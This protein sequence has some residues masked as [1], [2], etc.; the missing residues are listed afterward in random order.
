MIHVLIH[1]SN[2]LQ[3]EATVQREPTNAKA[4]FDLGVKQQENERESQALLALRRAVELDPVHLPSWLALATSST[5]EGLRQ[6]TIDAAREWV[7]RN[8]R[9]SNTVAVH[10]GPGETFDSLIAC[11]I[12]MARHA[13]EEVDA[14]VQIALAVLLNANEDYHKAY[15]CFQTALAAR[16]DDWVLYN[17]VGATL[18]NSGAADQAISY[19]Y[20]AL[21]LNP[22]YIRARFNL[23]I[24]CISLG[25]YEE[26]AH[27]ILDALMLQDSDSVHGQD[28][29]GVTTTSLWDSLRTTC[30]H[31]KRID[32]ASLCDS[33]NLDSMRTALAGR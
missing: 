11:L 4:W 2:V 24:S 10:G 14:D 6:D 7:V 33:R 32:L 29:R 22:G 5:N 17:R 28:S 23:G 18:A 20:R 27:H 21:E 12:S 8:E 31:M 30:L 3:L 9:Y 26:A 15:D 25:R 19:Y 16:P 1:S 13:G